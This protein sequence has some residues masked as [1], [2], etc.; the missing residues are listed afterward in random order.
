MSRD[1]GREGQ[2]ETL[3]FLLS[4]ME[5]C[6]SSGSKFG[7]PLGQAA[8]GGWRG[9]GVPQEGSAGSWRPGSSLLQLKGSSRSGF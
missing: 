4:V 7:R 6:G 2:A 8:R 9:R 5:A 1:R 3:G